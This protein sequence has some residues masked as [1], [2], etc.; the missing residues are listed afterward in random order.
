MAFF[1][2]LKGNDSKHK[3]NGNHHHHHISF[4]PHVS[5]TWS[6]ETHPSLQA[7]TRL[8]SYFRALLP[9]IIEFYILFFTCS[10]NVSR[11]S[12]EGITIGDFFPP[13]KH[14]VTCW[15]FICKGFRKT[16]RHNGIFKK[17]VVIAVMPLAQCCQ[18][19]CFAIAH[20]VLNMT[21]YSCQPNHL[22]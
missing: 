15:R 19:L 18:M 7:S 22:K 1:Q 12:S 4:H 16:Y 5:Q 8:K 20:G 2:P 13:N 14:A 9:G 17:W 21:L 10:R 3:G 11:P 6:T